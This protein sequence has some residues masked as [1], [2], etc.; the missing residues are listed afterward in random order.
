VSSSIYTK[1]FIYPTPSDS[2]L[3]VGDATTA[4]PSA[5]GSLVLKKITNRGNT[6]KNTEKNG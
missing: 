3:A 2:M 5:N 4:V 6:K 1:F